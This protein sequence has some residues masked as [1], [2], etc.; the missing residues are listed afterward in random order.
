[1]KAIIIKQHSGVATPTAYKMFIAAF[2]SSFTRLI[3]PLKAEP[4]M[5]T[6]LGGHEYAF[7]LPNK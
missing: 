3:K 2:F 7:V 1:M 5:N 4:E 6:S